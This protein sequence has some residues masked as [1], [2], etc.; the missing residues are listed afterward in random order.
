MSSP[1]PSTKPF[2]D[3]KFDPG[4]IPVGPRVLVWPIPVEEKSAGG[5]VLIPSQTERE[6]MAQIRAVVVDV[7][8]E[9]FVDSEIWAF[10]GDTVL[11]AKYA[12]LY[13][14]GDDGR[15]YRVINDADIVAKIIVDEPQLTIIEP[16]AQVVEPQ[17]IESRESVHG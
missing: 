3:V 11:I 9:A 10:K 13:W 4:L 1:L 6:D 16:R 5:I 17:G 7:G 14:T 2:Q 8:E 15:K 12:G